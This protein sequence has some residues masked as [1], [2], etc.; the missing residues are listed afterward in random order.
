MPEI[1]GRLED[2]VVEPL[3]RRISRK[4]TKV[5]LSSLLLAI[6]LEDYPPCPHY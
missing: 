2:A 3:T 1:V 4:I 5:R 6:G